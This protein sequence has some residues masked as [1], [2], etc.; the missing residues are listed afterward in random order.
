LMYLLNLIILW[1]RPVSLQFNHL[2]FNQH[3]VNHHPIKKMLP[4]QVLWQR[5]L[6]FWAQVFYFHFDIELLSQQKN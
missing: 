2:L 6:Q 1:N 3:S 4:D 5:L